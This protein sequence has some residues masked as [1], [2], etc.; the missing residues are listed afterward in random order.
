MQCLRSFLSAAMEG[1]EEALLALVQR[2]AVRVVTAP[3]GG[4]A[5]EDLCAS[6]G[7]AMDARHRPLLCLVFQLVLAQREAFDNV[8]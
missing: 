7:A 4:D 2:V 1:G 8:K 5:A 3:A 6:L